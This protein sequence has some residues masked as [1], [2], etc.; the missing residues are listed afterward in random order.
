MSVELA[1]GLVDEDALVAG[2]GQRV[3]P[4]CVA[5]QCL[6]LLHVGERGLGIAVYVAAGQIRWMEIEFEQDVEREEANE[7][8]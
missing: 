5:P 8:V 1:R 7:D 2:A 6:V 3:A 4:Q